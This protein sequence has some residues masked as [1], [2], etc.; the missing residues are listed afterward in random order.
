MNSIQPIQM[1]GTQRSGSNLLRLLLNQYPEIVAPH[2]PHILQRFYPLLPVYGDLSNPENLKSLVDD[3][4]RLVEKNPVPWEGIS[5]DR[6]KIME[7]CRIPHIIEIFKGIYDEMAQYH[8]ATM[9]IC[10]SMSNVDYAH[11]MEDLGLKPFYIYLVRDGR[12][13]ACSFK[14]AIVGEKHIFHIARQWR[15]D[16]LASLQLKQRI[17]SNRFFQISYESLIQNPEM[18]MFRLSSFL[19]I[20]YNPAIFEYYHS[21]ESKNTASAGKMWENVSK[22]IL[23]GNSK[24]YLKELPQEEILIFESVAGDIL[25]SLGYHLEYPDLSRKHVIT[26]DD[27]SRFEL[28]NKLL[29][30]QSIHFTDPEGVKLRQPQDELIAGIKNHLKTV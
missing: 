10:K 15:K 29:K 16:Q 26:K 30:E 7:N 3:I 18:E 19:K 27:I 6:R 2:P 17:G 13:V 12:D 1:I 23:N 24:K 5:L 25:E 21:Q 9:W 11:Q 22:P 4:C 14:Q 8:K 20:K 28:E